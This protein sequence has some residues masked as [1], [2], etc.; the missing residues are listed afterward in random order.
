MTLEE[1]FWPSSQVGAQRQRR[2]E[3]KL[4]EWMPSIHVAV[5]KLN[6]QK[7]ISKKVFPMASDLC[8]QLDILT[9]SVENQNCLKTSLQVVA[10]V[11]TIDN[12]SSIRPGMY[13]K[14]RTPR[15]PK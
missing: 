13:A 10:E 14:V 8:W 1:L 9:K 5:A 15:Q 2:T 12:G 11:R 6:P 7:M 4:G 3:R